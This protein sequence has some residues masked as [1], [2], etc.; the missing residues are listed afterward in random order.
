[1]EQNGK[2]L[3]SEF[4]RH[5]LG[6]WRETAH[7]LRR[8]SRVIVRCE[9]ESELVVSLKNSFDAA[10]SVIGIHDQFKR[11][12]GK[13][14]LNKDPRS[15]QRSAQYWVH[16]WKLLEGLDD[17]RFRQVAIYS[18]FAE[19]AGILSSRSAA[20]V[21][22]PGRRAKSEQRGCSRIRMTWTKRDYEI[23]S[24]DTKPRLATSQTLLG[25]SELTI[26]DDFVQWRL[27]APRI[28]FARRFSSRTK[29]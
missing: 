9:T 19:R 18:P 7:P 5:L 10:K 29:L 26:F 15:N 2:T 12:L 3:T 8:V 14:F 16:Q 4:I 23:I 27:S 24:S 28:L 22:N 25:S 13:I 21:R 11:S 17:S 1:M 20:S 6:P